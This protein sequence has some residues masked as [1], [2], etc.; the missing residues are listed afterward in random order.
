MQVQVQRDWLQLTGSD[1]SARVISQEVGIRMGE[2][3]AGILAVQDRAVLILMMEA[4]AARR[5][6]RSLPG[7]E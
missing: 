4:A 3:R 2:E 5:I 7:A 1:G 6:L